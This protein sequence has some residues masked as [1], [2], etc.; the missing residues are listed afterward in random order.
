MNIR[1]KMI[2]RIAQDGKNANQETT[3]YIDKESSPRE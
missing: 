1:Q 3:G 2:F